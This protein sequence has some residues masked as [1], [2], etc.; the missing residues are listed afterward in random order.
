[1]RPNGLVF[2]NFHQRIA[3]YFI[4]KARPHQYSLATLNNPEKRA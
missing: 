4:D 2:S 3:V 1:M